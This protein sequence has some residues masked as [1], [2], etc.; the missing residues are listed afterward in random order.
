[1][2]TEQVILDTGVLVALLNRR[3][4]YHSW[5]V[6][7]WKQVHSPAYTCDAVIS[8]ACFL[9]K[10][11]YLINAVFEMLTVGALELSFDLQ[12][13]VESVRHLMQRYES[14]PISV[15]DACLVRMSELIKDSVV[16]TLDSDFQI[17]RRFQKEIIPIIQPKLF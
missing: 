3:D 15:A 14:V 13:E 10:K 5:A 7:Q 17:Y 11:G 4:T 16:L 8:E 2:I 6:E 1:M 12:A 9:L